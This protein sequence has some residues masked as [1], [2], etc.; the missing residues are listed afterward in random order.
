M[1]S[2]TTVVVADAGPLIH[3][4][5][6]G[7]LADEHSNLRPDCFGFEVLGCKHRDGMLGR[8]GV[9]STDARIYF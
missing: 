5:E 9:D 4:D 2:N 3:L 1:L 8:S 6:L 7:A